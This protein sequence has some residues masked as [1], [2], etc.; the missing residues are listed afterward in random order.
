MCIK[1]PP[2]TTPKY[3][4]KKLK[5]FLNYKS[6]NIL[7]NENLKKK[8]GTFQIKYNNPWVHGRYKKMGQHPNSPLPNIYKQ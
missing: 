4:N 5:S 3:N 7:V 8:N 6:N 2:L 1:S